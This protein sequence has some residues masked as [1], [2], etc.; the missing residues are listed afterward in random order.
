MLLKLRQD[1][2]GDFIQFTLVVNVR[3][4]LSSVLIDKPPEAKTTARHPV[5]KSQPCLSQI[6]V[7]EAENGKN[8]G[9]TGA[10]SFVVVLAL[11]HQLLSNI[12]RLLNLNELY[13]CGVHLLFPPSSA[14]I[15][16]P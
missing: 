5:Q 9:Y 10:F 15:T 12:H 3:Q 13:C 4:P 2:S 6:E 11:Q 8:R 7:M 16:D 1:E 14:G